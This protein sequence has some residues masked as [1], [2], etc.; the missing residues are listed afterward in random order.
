MNVTALKPE[1]ETTK[2]EDVPQSKPKED[3]H[4][5]VPQSVPDS[6]YEDFF[7]YFSAYD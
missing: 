3:V 4:N 1:T 2:S 7:D 6:R 5:V